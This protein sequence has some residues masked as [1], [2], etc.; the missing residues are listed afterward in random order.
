VASPF[1]SFNACGVSMAKAVSEFHGLRP[2]HV[3]GFNA[4]AFLCFI[5]FARLNSYA[6]NIFLG[7]K[8]QRL[9]GLKPFLTFCLLFF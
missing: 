8:A 9:T 1:L 5:G 7:S 3:S 6:V 2:F 4:L